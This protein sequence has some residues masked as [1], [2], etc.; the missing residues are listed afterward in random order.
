MKPCKHYSDRALT[1]RFVSNVDGNDFAEAVRDLDPAET[2][3]IVASK[4]FT[5]LETMT[6]AETARDWLLAGL[7]GERR[8]WPGTSSPSRPMPTRSRSSAS[9][10]PTCS[11]SGTGSAGVI[12]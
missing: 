1:F 10:P 9:T 6:N 2:L 12:P 5:T 11:S 3:F 7:G 8:P 4:T